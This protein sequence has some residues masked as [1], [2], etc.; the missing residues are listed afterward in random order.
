MTRKKKKSLENMF[1]NMSKLED[2]I[3]NLGSFFFFKYMTRIKGEFKLI[4]LS[5]YLIVYVQL[6]KFFLFLNITVLLLTF[7]K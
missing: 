1:A 5:F 2:V 4:F 3:Y 7:N 6:F